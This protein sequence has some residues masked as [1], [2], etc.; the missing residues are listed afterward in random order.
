[1]PHIGVCSPETLR[2]KRWEEASLTVE[3]ERDYG[4][5]GGVLPRLE[6]QACD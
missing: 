6:S 4:E 1:M 2:E 5:S 3:D